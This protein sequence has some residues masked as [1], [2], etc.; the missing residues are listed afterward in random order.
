MYSAETFAKYYGLFFA[1][2]ANAAIR[3]PMLGYAS[4]VTGNPFLYA[5]GVIP[6]RKE[7]VKEKKPA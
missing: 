6:E 3:G 1:F 7:K 5:G 4:L 2:A